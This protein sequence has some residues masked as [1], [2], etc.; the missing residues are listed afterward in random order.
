VLRDWPV[1]KDE[2]GTLVPIELKNLPFEAKRI[3]YVCNVPK[4]EERG[5]H[6]HYETKQILTCIQG[7]IKV[8]LHNGKELTETLLQE[9]ESVFIDKMIWDSQVFLT[10]N[11]VLLSICSTEYSIEDY[12]DDFQIFLDV[13]KG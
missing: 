9:N 2:D 11:D 7:R 4:G 3:F 12:I 13:A 1:F 10:G 8:K 5:M 6:A